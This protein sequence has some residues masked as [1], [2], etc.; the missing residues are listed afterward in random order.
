MSY[1]R[2]EKIIK[3]GALAGHIVYIKSGLV[4]VYTEHSNE[5]MVISIENKGTFIG[6]Q[7]LYNEKVY[8]YSV[9]AY[10]D[11]SGLSVGY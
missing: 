4:K 8:P 3:E 9:K 5:E 1:N 7:S 10:E 6:L 11:V 2:G